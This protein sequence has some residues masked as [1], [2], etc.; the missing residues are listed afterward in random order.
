MS[1]LEQMSALTR[2]HNRHLLE[3]IDLVA[4]NSWISNW[5]RLT[6]ASLLSNSYCIG[7]P[8]KR[9]Y[10]GCTFID[11]IEDLV[12][13]LT[14]EIFG[15]EFAVVQFLSGMQANFAAYNSIL[16]PGDSVVA[17]PAR[18]GGHYSHSTEGP[19]RFFRCRLLP[20]PFDPSC[21]N[22][23]TERLEALLIAERPRLL[24][25]GWSEFLFPHPLQEIRS[26]C[27]RHG[28][29]LMY[30]MSHVAGLLA[31]GIFQPEAGNLADIVTSSTGKSL[32]APDHGLCLYNNQ[33]FSAGLRDAVMPLLTSNI[34]PHELAALGIALAEMKSFGASYAQQ[35]VRNSKALGRALLERGLSVLYSEL[36]FTESHTILLRCDWSTEAISLLDQAGISANPTPLPWDCEDRCSGIRIGTQVVTRR[37]MSEDDMEAIADALAR[38]LLQREDPDRVRHSLVTPLAL[39]HQDTAFSFDEEFLISKDWQDTAYHHPQ[40]AARLERGMPQPEA[41]SVSDKQPCQTA[42]V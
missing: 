22:I 17:A 33:D 34:H 24:I 5:A 18:F 1:L 2:L 7:T 9:L 26:I 25:V 16:S 31:G 39:A 32:H 20:V 4:S 37:G 14:T 30:D 15:S 13:E 41:P 11:K 19:L 28:T 12:V 38:I 8:G 21:Y 40:A 27:D 35:V 29:A 42:L 36:D 10:G 6:M 3:R 23:D